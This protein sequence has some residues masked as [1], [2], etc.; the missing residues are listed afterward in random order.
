MSA[1]LASSAFSVLGAPGADRAAAIGVNAVSGVL[2]VFRAGRFS[3][4]RPGVWPVCRGR[5]GVSST[6]PRFRTRTSRAVVRSSSLE[7]QAERLGRRA[8]GR[9]SSGRGAG[10]SVRARSLGSLRLGAARPI[11]KSSVAASFCDDRAVKMSSS[12][13]RLCS[14]VRWMEARSLACSDT[15][16]SYMS[17]S[18]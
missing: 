8:R 13:P 17:V 4:R 12:A 2:A 1:R 6:W 9:G 14:A 15:L 7:S 10:V 11:T 18:V 3:P 5:S 16:G